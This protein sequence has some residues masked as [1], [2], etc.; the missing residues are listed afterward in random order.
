MS[1]TEATT[2]FPYSNI[3]IFFLLL[4]L[5][6]GIGVLIMNM[7]NRKNLVYGKKKTKRALLSFSMARE[8]KMFSNINLELG[9]T[10]VHFDYLVIG[11]FG[12]F[13]LNVIEPSGEYCGEQNDTT[14]TRTQDAHKQSIPNPLKQNQEGLAILKKQIGKDVSV[15]KFATEQL[16]VFAGSESKTILYTKSSDKICYVK[17]LKKSLRHAKFNQDNDVNVAQLSEYIASK[18]V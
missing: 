5:V 4:I 12:L 10:K 8:F 3:V 17:E 11:F 2:V 9:E 7:S 6:F 1:T 16:T 18:I 13:A 14:W 15:Y